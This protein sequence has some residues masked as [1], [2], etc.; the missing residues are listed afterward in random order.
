[1]ELEQLLQVYAEAYRTSKSPRGAHVEAL[2]AVVE[3]VESAFERVIRH[4]VT[5]LERDGDEHGVAGSLNALL[6]TSFRNQLSKAE[7]QGRLSTLKK[8]PLFLIAGKTRSGK[9]VISSFLPAPRKIRL[10]LDQV[11]PCEHTQPPKRN[12]QF[13]EIKAKL[14]AQSGQLM[15]LWVTRKPDSERYIL[16]QGGEVRYAA[17]RELWE[18]TQDRNFFELDFNCCELFDPESVTKAKKIAENQIL[19]GS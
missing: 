18:E 12:H 8:S 14:Q 11:A 2:K 5:T 19:E 7:L 9:G 3:R 16:A 4:A 10:N 15:P 1:M 13:H 17:L 6:S